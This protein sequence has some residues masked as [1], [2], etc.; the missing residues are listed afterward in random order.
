MAVAGR[1]CALLLDGLSGCIDHGSVSG[2]FCA[3]STRSTLLYLFAVML[4]CG[5]V[6][7]RTRLIVT[8]P[9]TARRPKYCTHLSRRRNRERRFRRLTVCLAFFKHE[10]THKTH[11]HVCVCAR[12]RECVH[13]SSDNI[14]GTTHHAQRTTHPPRCQC[15]TT[16]NN[17]P[18]PIQT[19]CS[20]RAHREVSEPP[21]PCSRRESRALVPA[22]AAA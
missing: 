8:S 9:R 13:P 18:K 10:N 20:S 12:S 22:A 16:P 6:G 2:S 19:R 21:R 15:S 14:R 4:V 7:A 11:T 3:S 17:S 5:L 1:L